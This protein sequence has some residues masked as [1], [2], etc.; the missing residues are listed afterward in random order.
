MSRKR[1]M[2][3]EDSAILLLPQ[4]IL[5]AMGVTDGDEID[6]SVTEGTLTLR[7]LDEAE[8]VRNLGAA[9]DAVIKRRK[10]AYEELA[11]GAE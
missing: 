4:E 8:R 5:D 1:I 3:S 6:V 2:A 7:S 9:A 11:K 10:A